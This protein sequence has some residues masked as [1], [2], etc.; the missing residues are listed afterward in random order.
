MSLCMLLRVFNVISNPLG[1]LRLATPAA[2]GAES[3][4]QFLCQ[5]HLFLNI[6]LVFIFGIYESGNINT[7]VHSQACREQH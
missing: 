7:I 1:T 4:K 6:G 3:L 2:Q 5:S